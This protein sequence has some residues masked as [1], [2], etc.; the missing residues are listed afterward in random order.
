M[1][2][3][4]VNATQALK[5]LDRWRPLTAYLLRNGY[6]VTVARCWAGVEWGNTNDQCLNPAENDELGLCLYHA[7]TLVR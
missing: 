7:K 1:R 4:E 6:G 5:D 3:D 2:S